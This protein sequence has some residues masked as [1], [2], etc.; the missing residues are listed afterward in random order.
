MPTVTP[1]PLTSSVDA[2]ASHWLSLSDDLGLPAETLRQRLGELIRDYVHARSADLARGVARYS[3]ALS[4]H[5]EL[6]DEPEQLVGLCRL[7][8]HWRLL[9]AQCEPH[10]A[11]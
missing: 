11:G 1:E 6:R 2:T 9:A 10:P 7:S 8:R 3:A 5:P 4:L